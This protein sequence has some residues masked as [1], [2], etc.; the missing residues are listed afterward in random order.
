MRA[1]RRA[2]G[3]KEQRHWVERDVSEV[4]SD[5]RIA[6]IRSLALHALVARK[7]LEDPRLVE[8]AR[9]NLDRWELSGGESPPWMDEWRAVLARPTKEIAAYLV[10]TSEDAFRLR[11]SSPFAGALTPEERRAVFDAFRDRR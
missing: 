6:E 11:Q 4:W 8:R 5:H 7:V 2:A 1:R 9:A 10:S 3:L